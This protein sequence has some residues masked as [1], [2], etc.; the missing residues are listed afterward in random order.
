M[1]NTLL[2]CALV[3]ALL[4][5]NLS[6]G[7]KQD[8]ANV[9]LNIGVMDHQGAK[10]YDLMRTIST[11]P[12]LMVG[13]TCKQPNLFAVTRLNNDDTQMYTYPISISS[14]IT[15]TTPANATQ[16][17][18]LFTSSTLD[19]E[20]RF[21]V[22]KGAAFDYGVF[23]A[24]TDPIDANNDG[25]CDQYSGA[26]PVSG[27]IYSTYVGAGHRKTEVS[28]DTV[29]NLNVFVVQSNSSNYALSCLDP[30]SPN[31]DNQL[32]ARKDFIRLEKTLFGDNDFSYVKVEYLNALNRSERVVQYFNPPSTL[33]TFLPHLFPMTITFF[34]PTLN[35]TY[36]QTLTGSVGSSQPTPTP[37]LNVTDPFWAWEL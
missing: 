16:I 2:N 30:N 14:T 6:C 8:F 32:C 33:P 27:S 35:T 18:A 11:A 28:G 20:I 10:S 5:V 29:L 17:T 15:G 34:R 25:T 37:G 31:N 7:K 1:N 36:T 19:S 21:P 24:L 13:G 22:P 3:L 12:N 23:G 26:A 4:A 9:T